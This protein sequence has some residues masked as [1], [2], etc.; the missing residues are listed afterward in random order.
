[1][2]IETKVRARYLNNTYNV[3]VKFS[4]KHNE[5]MS[6]KSYEIEDVPDACVEA[7]RH[8]Q[9]R[10]VDAAP[11]LPAARAVLLSR[12][13]QLQRGAHCADLRRGL[14]HQMLRVNAHELCYSITH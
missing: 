11:A 2:K 6:A 10:A 13:V 5:M 3:C 12:L 4:F 9:Q 7:G 14:L 8:A 1:M